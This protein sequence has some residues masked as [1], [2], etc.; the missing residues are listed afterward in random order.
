MHT[1]FN[2][3]F[4][5]ERNIKRW[6]APTLKEMKRR[7]LKMGP[8]A[9]VH[10]STFLDWNYHSELYAFGKRLGEDFRKDVLQCAFTHR[11]Y[12][13]QEEMKQKEVGIE[14]PK[15]WLEDNEELAKMGEKLMSEYLKQHLRV[16]LPRFPE[17]GICGIND[18]LMSD[19]TLAHVSKHIGTT[20]IIL[21]SDF[22][23]TDTTLAKTF[24]AIVGALAESSGE[25]K[26]REF[27]RDFVLTQLAGKDVNEIWVV[28]D[29]MK[30]L[31]DILKRDGKSEP[32]PRLI[33][34]CGRNT[35]LASYQV[36]VYCSKEFMGVGYGETI[37]I[38]VEM[39]ARDA[40]KRLFQ[41]TE[42]MK[43]IPFTMNV[44]VPLNNKF[45]Q[46]VSV[47]N[48]NSKNVPNVVQC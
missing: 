45:K 31:T 38:A 3:Y 21:C 32:E 2:L 9:P 39:A 29:P 34:E 43:P 10:R 23:V 33:N 24:K 19:A 16:A 6:V 15:L 36:A 12:I 1:L 37:S 14:D 40:L 11:S 26:A 27:V 8:E 42:N 17:E 4:E 18:Y 7:K 30:I 22:P 13:I 5:S 44:N 41:T 25:D 35:I 20:D 46:N 28:Q 48:W 47:D